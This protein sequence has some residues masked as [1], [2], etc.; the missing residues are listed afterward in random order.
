MR[1]VSKAGAGARRAL[2]FLGVGATAALGLAAKDVFEFEKSL[3]RLQI[4][5][6]RTPRQMAAFRDRIDEVS[7]SSGIAREELLDVSQRFVSLTGDM[8]TAETLLGT[9]AKTA[10][11]SGAATGDLAR[12]AF[13]LQKNF[14]IMDPGQ[15]EKAFSIILSAGKAGSVELKEMASLLTTIAP[16]FSKFG[17]VGAD[18]LAEL[19]GAFQVVQSGFAGPAEAA[20]AMNAIFTALIKNA[21]RFKKAGIK[22]FEIGPDGEK[23]LRNFR[24]L[25]GEIA[26]S[27]LAKDPTLLVKAFGRT[28]AVRAFSELAKFAPEWD[29]IAASA[30]KADDVAKD[31]AIFDESTAGRMQKSLAAL[32]SQMASIFTPT[33]INQ[34]AKALGAVVTAAG[35]LIE[36][37]EDIDWAIDRIMNKRIAKQVNSV[38]IRESGKRF[39]FG[40]DLVRGARGGADGVRRRLA[41]GNADERDIRA[42]REFLAEAR[43]RGFIDASGNIDEQRLGAYTQERFGRLQ[44]L[45]ANDRFRAA[46]PLARRAAALQTP[47][48]RTAARRLQEATATPRETGVGVAEGLPPGL[49][50]FPNFQPPSDTRVRLEH[51]FRFDQDMNASVETRRNRE[52]R[53]GGDQ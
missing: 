5:A 10:R 48:Q 9:F 41:A 44:G 50:R 31:S 39:G 29:Q 24:D 25:V 52:A 47:A 27:K 22:V 53:R 49:Q 34:F 15:F 38:G 23:R 26:E 32:Q 4:Q 3:T 17:T 12:V 40:E 35:F 46:V 2:S 21:D 30:R 1:S 43:R 28:E 20:T 11:A 36:R 8:S 14:D 13:S 45:V 18:G 19:S 33:R 42:G 7:R 6:G 37:F 51:T 16:Q